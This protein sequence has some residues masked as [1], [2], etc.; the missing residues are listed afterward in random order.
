MNETSHVKPGKKSRL[1]LILLILI[2]MCNNMDRHIIA[3]LAEP[4]RAD[5]KFSDTQLGMISGLI[6]AAFYTAFG[7]PVGWIADRFGRIRVIFTAATIWS[8]CSAMGGLA[9]NFTQLAAARVGVA[10]GEAGG[11]APSYSLLS[12]FYPPERRGNVLGIFHL[13]APIGVLLASFIASWVTIHFGWRAAIVAVS[14]PGA[15]FA[16]ILILTVREPAPE[17]TDSEAP[18]FFEA[19]KRYMTQPLLVLAGVGAGFSS[20]M[21]GVTSAWVPAF[22]MRV[23]GMPLESLG[24]WYAIGNALAFGLGIWGGGI[25]ADRFANRGLRIYALVPAIGVSVAI[26]F[27]LFASLV[28]SWHLSLIAWLV[29]IA[30]VAMFL[31]PSVALVQNLAAPEQRAI[32][33]G[34]F[35][36]FTYLIGSGFGPLYVGVISDW[37]KPTV[38]DASL[39]YAMIACVPIMLLA[40]ALQIILARMLGTGE[41]R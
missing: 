27:V 3:I 16:L 40:V 32:S 8:I 26:P 21:T 23:R 36:L 24:S 33:G 9:G 25:L 18:P 22:L 19:L 2:Y 20:F 5:L 37:L 28:P 12:S 10:L 15:I 39:A 1:V 35:L 4:I 30:S 7:V 31:A 41:R 14:L 29:P 34:I 17:R 11:A 13:G 38:G 6:F